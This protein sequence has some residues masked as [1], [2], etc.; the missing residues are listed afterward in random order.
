VLDVHTGEVRGIVGGRD[1][2]HSAFDR[3]LLARRQPGSAF[4][5]IVYA[6]AMHAGLSTA[7]RVETTPVEVAGALG[8][9]RPDDLVPDSVTSLTVRNALALSSNNAAVRIGEWVGVERVIEMARTLGI[10]TPIPSVP[11]IFL[12]AAEVAPVELAAAYATLGNGG[13]SVKPTLI[14][15][16][17]D[18]RGRVLWRT[19]QQQNQT[20]DEGVAF[21]TTSMLQ[22]VIDHGTGNAVRRDG[23]WLPA[24][25]KTGTTNGAKDVWFVGM[26]PDLVAAVWLGFDQPKEILPN[27]FGGNLAAP[28]WSQTMKAAY[29]ERAAPAAWTAPASLISMPID[30]ESGFMASPECPP[31]DVRIEYFF[32]GSEPTE[33]CPLHPRRGNGII[34]RLLRGIGVR[35]GG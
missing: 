28:I 27:A 34:D 15:R 31:A 30:G 23:F 22:D 19:P 25:G 18:A 26:T 17:E 12:G 13:R 4:K 7:A 10:T 24:A 11:S 32:P 29:A 16:V 20:L 33:Y 6:A 9:W 14:T 35:G 8:A 5:P 3:A 2:T 1:F 21:L